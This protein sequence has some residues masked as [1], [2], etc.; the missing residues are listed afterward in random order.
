MSWLKRHAALAWPALLLAGLV[1]MVALRIGTDRSTPSPAEGRTA[2]MSADERKAG[3][4][5]QDMLNAAARQG[6]SLQDRISSMREQ[7]EAIQVEVSAKRQ[8][9]G[10]LD[11]ML[12]TDR[13]L[14][15]PPFL[16]DDKTVRALQEVIRETAATGTFE[17]S[18]GSGRAEAILVAHERL[19][20]GWR[21]FATR[22]IATS[23]CWRRVRRC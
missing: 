22:F 9:A 15:N 2:E 21:I 13:L 17:A 6:R 7:L 11:V 1:A 4:G 23:R 14:Q 16:Q 20:K 19:R 5:S 10:E 12:A 8:Q 3:G 18:G